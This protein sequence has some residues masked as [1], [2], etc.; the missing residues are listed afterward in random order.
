MAVKGFFF[1]TEFGEGLLDLRE[2][3]HGIVAKS[4]VTTEMVENAALGDSAKRG[5]HSAIFCG[6]DHTNE[7]TRSLCF[8]NPSE[9]TEH[10][11]VIGI[12]VR[13]SPGFVRF[14]GGIAGG[15]HSGSAIQGI[16]LKTRVIRQHDLPG[17][18]ETV[19]LSFL[20]RIF[21]EGC[22][23]FD[24]SRQRRELRNPRNCDAMRA[25]G[26]GKV[27]KLTRIRGSDQNV[28][29]LWL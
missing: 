13:V 1:G 11:R 25:G 22:S 21:F 7:P 8:W 15:V 16:D 23:I 18:G 5:Q 14:I 3:E 26:S 9:F 27:A 6:C 2:I 10:A 12:I 4:A 17:R 24:D 28:F 20:A 29:H 19:L